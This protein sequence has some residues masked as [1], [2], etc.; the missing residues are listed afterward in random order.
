MKTIKMY[1]LHCLR[2]DEHWISKKK[3]PTRCGKIACRSPYW[4]R[5]RKK[6]VAK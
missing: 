2:C 3:S 6:G 4:N 1:E 5:P